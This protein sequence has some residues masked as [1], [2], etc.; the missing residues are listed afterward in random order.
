MKV[1]RR[2]CMAMLLISFPGEVSSLALLGQESAPQ[3]TGSA[4]SPQQAAAPEVRRAAPSFAFG[5]EDTT[6]IKLK[7]ARE[8]SSAREK[9]GDR[10]S[11]VEGKSVDLGG[12][13]I[14]K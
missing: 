11:V 2:C 6:P 3:K 12:R 13:R 5:L 9:T 4:G 14:I 1:F 8:L 10:K 7:L